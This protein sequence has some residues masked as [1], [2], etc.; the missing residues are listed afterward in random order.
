[1]TE[2]LD[3]INVVVANRTEGKMIVGNRIMDAKETKVLTIT[4]V[5][6]M[7]RLFAL[8]RK[9]LI[10]IR[11]EVTDDMLD[12]LNGVLLYDNWTMILATSE[13][14]I[15]NLRGMD[16]KQRVLLNAPGSKTLVEYIY[17]DGEFKPLQVAGPA[18]PKGEQGIPGPVGPK[19]DEG[20]RGPQG[21][22]GVDGPKGD[23]GPVGSQGEPGDKGEPGKLDIKNLTPEDIKLLKEK[24][25]L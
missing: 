19:G 25:G 13:E 1:M 6:Q 20:K 5:V 8:E 18:G 22:R 24:L 14:E 23:Q 11:T 16:S 2:N 3:S 7:E 9:N 12:K 21:M 10:V 4:N 15:H 17:I